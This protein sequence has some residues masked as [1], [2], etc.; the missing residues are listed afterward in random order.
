MPLQWGWTFTGRCARPNAQLPSPVLIYM[1]QMLS[2]DFVS[3]AKHFPKEKQEGEWG[4]PCQ[5]LCISCV[6]HGSHCDY[7]RARGDLSF[8]QPV[9][10]PVCGSRDEST[11]HSKGWPLHCHSPPALPAMPGFL[12][13]HWSWPQKYTRTFS[14]MP[15]TKH[16]GYHQPF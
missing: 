6:T 13:H 10:C 8:P 12:A 7:S 15:L 3:N 16:L 9:V 2:E 4:I 11:Q 14:Q 1:A 5:D